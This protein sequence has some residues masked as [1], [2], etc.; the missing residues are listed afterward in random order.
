M[1]A[2]LAVIARLEFE[3]SNREETDEFVEDE[4]RSPRG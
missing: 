1:E 3:C 2:G 4:I